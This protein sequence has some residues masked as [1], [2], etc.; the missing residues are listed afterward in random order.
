[1]IVHIL[2]QGF[3]LCGFG[4]GQFPGE[5]PAGH[6]WTYLNDLEGVTCK[7][8]LAAA[9]TGEN[10]CKENGLKKGKQ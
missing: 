6:K 10:K 8:C 5:W 9:N 1:M 2:H 3:T 4:R 7:A